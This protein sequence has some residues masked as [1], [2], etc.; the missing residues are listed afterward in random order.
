VFEARA[1]AAELQ[2]SPGA[3]HHGCRRVG[4]RAIDGIRYQDAVGSL[5]LA[6]T[7]SAAD[8]PVA[9]LTLEGNAIN[10]VFVKKDLKAQTGVA[11]D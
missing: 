3:S 1:S 9:L 11:D 6:L 10:S 7:F 8:N 4:V 2:R 5:S